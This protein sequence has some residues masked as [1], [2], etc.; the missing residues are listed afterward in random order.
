MYQIIPREG[1][2]RQNRF[3]RKCLGPPYEAR[4]MSTQA[5]NEAFARL[6]VAIEPWLEEVVIIG[7]WA[8][9]LYRLHPSAQALDYVPL[10]T[11]DAD[12]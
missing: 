9:Q 2:S 11:L 5:G 6:V 7:G 1:R 8:H 3:G 10:T 4:A 12:R